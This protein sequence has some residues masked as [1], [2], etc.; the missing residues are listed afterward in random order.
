VSRICLGC[1]SYG[2]SKWGPW[3]LDEEASLPLIKK[4]YDLGI[5]FF[6]T[7]DVY[8]SGESEKVLGKAIKQFAFQRSKIV[9]ATKVFAAFVEGKPE[10]SLFGKNAEEFGLINQGGL[11]RKHIFDSVDGSLHRLGL[12]YID[13]YQIHRFDYKTPVEETMEA[14]ND[15]VRSGKVRYIGASSMFAWQFQKMNNV[16]KQHG[17]AQFVTMQNFYN[18]LYRE[19][20][21]EMIPYSLDANIGLIP[22]SPLAR[23][24]L[25]RRIADQKSTVRAASDRMQVP[26]SQ[27]DEQIITRVWEVADKL[28]VTGS[29]VALAWL[30]T[31][32]AVSSP[33]LGISSEDHLND[34]VSALD[35][36]LTPEDI[37]YL[38]EPYAPKQIA[39]HQ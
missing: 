18:L 30:W 10:L 12:D 35:L 26:L 3:V 29:Q 25:A 4:A 33:I 17:W 8:S 24:K 31:K 39:G 32:P 28:K 23:G 5:N 11:S 36:K 21:R 2:S 7:A 19:E 38:E 37:K 16:A 14:L 1:M 27:A 6:D 20:E 22:W 13:L 9:V 34:L 15:L